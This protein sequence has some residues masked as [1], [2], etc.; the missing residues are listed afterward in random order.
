MSQS[1]LSMT[2]YIGPAEIGPCIPTNTNA[3]TRTRLEQVLHDVQMDI[4]CCHILFLEKDGE[5]IDLTDSALRTPVDDAH[6]K[7]FENAETYK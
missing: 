7:W 5:S 6:K 4:S 1:N 3:S 2:I